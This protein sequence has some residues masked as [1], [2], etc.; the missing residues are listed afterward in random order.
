MSCEEN[1]KWDVQVAHRPKPRLLLSCAV[2]SDLSSFW[3]WT[4]PQLSIWATLSVTG[5]FYQFHLQEYVLLNI[6]TAQRGM[7][8]RSRSEPSTEFS[9]SICCNLVLWLPM[10]REQCRCLRVLATCYAVRNFWASWT[11]RIST[12][13]VCLPACLL[14]YLPIPTTHSHR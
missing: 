1:G 2:G 13:R 4:F 11:D 5:T 14:T 6:N 7:A 8:V 3:H 10:F 9:S 12:E